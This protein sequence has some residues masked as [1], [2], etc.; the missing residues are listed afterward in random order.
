MILPCLLISLMGFLP[1]DWGLLRQAL[2]NYE[3]QHIYPVWQAQQ[4]RLEQQISEKERILL[5]DLRL[6]YQETQTALTKWNQKP[7]L[8]TER[9]KILRKIQELKNA[10][11]PI[12]EKYA[13]T[14]ASFAQERDALKDK[15][16][17]DMQRIIDDYNITID[18]ELAPHFAKFNFARYDDEDTFLLDKPIPVVAPKKKEKEAKAGNREEERW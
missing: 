6:A 2:E 13:K 10:L 4:A 16:R 8:P 9:D 11:L 17:G 14:L 15:W 5:D 12:Q 18:L 1:P 7:T 3:R